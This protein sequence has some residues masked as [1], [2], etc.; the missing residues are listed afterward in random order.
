[1]DPHVHGYLIFFGNLFNFGKPLLTNLFTQ[2]LFDNLCCH[3]SCLFRLDVV[4][5]AAQVPS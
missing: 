3:V 4:F 5:T 2:L 1:M